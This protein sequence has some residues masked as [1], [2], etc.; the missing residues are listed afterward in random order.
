[1][2]KV[3]D[4]Q[5]QKNNPGR[6]S[7]FLD[8]EF[9]F[10]I[11]DIDLYNLGIKIGLEIDDEFMKV[12]EETVDFK[13]CLDYATNLV[14]KKMYSK[15]E[16]TGKLTLKGYTD[17]A[18][19]SSMDIMEEYGYINDDVYAKTYCEFKGKKDGAKKIRYELTL[20]GIRKDIIE[21]YI[22]EIENEDVLLKLL[23]NKLKGN[24]D[25]RKAIDKAIRY[26]IS[27]GFEYDKIK[28][29]L[30]KLGKDV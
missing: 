2:S 5:L 21:K 9:S 11:S 6:Y 23:E 8:G 1:M 20:K 27:K 30:N 7:V 18:I 12:I 28:G 10:G 19:K 17:S 13:K 14:S 3:T 15:K 22:A 4:I 29:C 26:G 25:E 16:L 24:P